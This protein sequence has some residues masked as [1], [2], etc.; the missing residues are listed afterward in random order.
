MSQFRLIILFILAVFALLFTGILL[1]PISSVFETI[2]LLALSGGGTAIVYGYD[3]AQLKRDGYNEL[4]SN[5]LHSSLETLFFFLFVVL[6]APLSFFY[7][8]SFRINVLL[9]ICLA[10]LIYSIPFK[11]YGKRMKL[12]HLVFVKN[13]F[14]G[15]S[16]GALILVGAGNFETSLIKAYF[17]FA[18]LQ[19]VVGS[20][21]RD[22]ADLEKDSL[23]GVVTVPVRFGVPVT[24]KVLHLLNVLSA[25]PLIFLPLNQGL[26]AMLP[27]FFWRMLVISRVSRDRHSLLW[28]QTCNILTCLMIGLV[29]AFFNMDLWLN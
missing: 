12:K 26:I 11:F 5:V 18:S 17:V 1:N 8:S 28:S 25:L 14:I 20:M 24:I 21:I 27:V 3:F 16:W 19:V 4:I 9:V 10:G 13:I 23:D 15:F 7:L 2:V 29:M 22:I 6:I